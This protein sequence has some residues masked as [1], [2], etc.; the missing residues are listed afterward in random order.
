MAE[1]ILEFRSG[2]WKNGNFTLDHG[3]LGATYD[4]AFGEDFGTFDKA[5]LKFKPAVVT[6]GRKVNAAATLRWYPNGFTPDEFGKAPRQ[7]DVNRPSEWV[8]GFSV[9]YLW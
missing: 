9:G 1:P 6:L 8:Y 5:G 4:I 2:S 3:V 7:N